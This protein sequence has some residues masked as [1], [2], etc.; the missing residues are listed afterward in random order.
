MRAAQVSFFAEENSFGKSHQVCGT[1]ADLLSSVGIF[2]HVKRGLS[3]GQNPA[4]DGKRKKGG[5]NVKTFFQ[6]L[7]IVAIAAI[8]V[9]ASF[10]ANSANAASEPPVPWAEITK[11]LEQILEKLNNPPAPA[12]AAAPAAPAFVPTDE[13]VL[14]PAEFAP[15]SVME[16]TQALGVSGEDAL[17]LTVL[18]ARPGE[19]TAIGWVLGTSSS[20]AAGK[21][22]TASHVPQGICVDYDPGASTLSGPKSWVVEFL[23]VWHRALT[24]DVNQFSGLKATF[25]WTECKSTANGVAG[26]PVDLPVVAIPIA[27]PPAAAEPTAAPTFSCPTFGGH[28]T[29]PLSDNGCK[30]GPSSVTTGKVPDGWWAH[31]W[32]GSKIVDAKSGSTIATGEATFYKNE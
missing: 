24:S 10:G 14:S 7:T 16:A 6:I 20:Q 31:F 2:P 5:K 30:Y 9:G 19:P 3:S 8:L 1:H 12:P 15:Q 32:D 23:P 29:K 27:T 26:K 25:Y 18:Y 28:T 22:L 4:M 11:L 17:F 21:I 13:H